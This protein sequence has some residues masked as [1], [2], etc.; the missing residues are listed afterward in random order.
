MTF[1]LQ[2]PTLLG[3]IIAALISL[4][5]TAGLVIA[6][7]LLFAGK[8]PDKT[9]TFVQQMA[10]RIG[11]MHAL[12]VALVFSIL[13][14]E[15]I[16]QY[17]HSDVEALSAANIYYILSDASTEPAVTIRDLIPIYLKTVIEQDWQV[18]S[19]RPHELPAW[20]LI[21]RMQRL[22]LDWHP[23]SQSE[24]MI[25]HYVFDNLNIMAE[26]RNKR[27]I[28]WQAP[29]LPSIFWG[30]AIGGYILTLV[31]YLCVELTRIR[32][33]LVCCYGAIIGL[34]FYGISVLDNP[35]KGRAIQPAPFE[36]M[37]ND[38]TSSQARDPAVLPND[39]K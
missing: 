3:A 33:F 39:G 15:L 29:N 6:A 1:L 16:K 12:V 36:V 2:L 22:T 27:V 26:N 14:G 31:P 21:S 13:T 10:L 32:L 5:I 11:T 8:R 18:F 9:L 4:A 28:E 7:H 30:I 38:I 34:M 23:T 25:K 35:F 17:S 37:Y 24:N 19:Q 20:K